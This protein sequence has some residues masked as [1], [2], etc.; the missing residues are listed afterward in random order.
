MNRNNHSDYVGIKNEKFDLVILEWC[1][2]DYLFG[3]ASHFNV[4][5]VLSVPNR[6]NSFIRQFTGNPNGISYIPAA[7]GDSANNNQMSFKER[8]VN[9]LTVSF[10]MAFTKYLE[11]YLHRPLYEKNFPTDRYPSFDDSKKN[12]AL[13]L[14]SHHFSQGP[15]E[16]YLPA[17][18][19]VGGMHITA[20]TSPLPDVREYFFF[21]MLE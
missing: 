14:V 2:N 20:K 12:I 5:L 1:I 21:F 7:F 9:Y 6:P 16:A 15:M 3:I 17:M 8:L 11:Y 10:E 13:V 18:V 19:E 4:P